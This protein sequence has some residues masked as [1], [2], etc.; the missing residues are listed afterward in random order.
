MPLTKI[1]I[2]EKIHNELGYG[3]NEASHLLESVL[4]LV[5]DSLASGEEVKISG[6]G[7]FELKQKKARR[8]RNPQTSESIILEAR[9]IVSFK[10][11]TLL[12]NRINNAD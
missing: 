12:K 2:A 1:D 6:F 3:K 5:K 4:T 7:K 9:R 8:G 10:L 11:S